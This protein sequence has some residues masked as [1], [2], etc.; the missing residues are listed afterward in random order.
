[1]KN[2]TDFRILVETGMDPRLALLVTLDLMRFC[3]H[4]TLFISCITE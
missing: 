3:I 1:M 2:L 4:L